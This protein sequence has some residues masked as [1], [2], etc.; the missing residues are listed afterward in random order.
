MARNKFFI[1]RWLGTILVLAMV[2]FAAQA[3]AAFKYIHE[4]M[5][6]QDF[7]GVDLV[8]GEKL[9][10]RKIRQG[11]LPIIIF[12]A[13]WSPRSQEQLEDVKEML[14]KY[15]EES[16][17]VIAVNVDGQK[18]T[19]TGRQKVIDYVAELNPPFSVMIDEGLDIFY[20]FG[21]IAVPSTAISDS[22]GILRFG[23]GGYA[24]STRDLLI[25]SIEAFLGIIQPDKAPKPKGYTPKK[26]SS[27][28]YYLASNLNKRG[29]FENALK[30]VEMARAADSNF[31]GP[32]TLQGEILMKLNRNDEAQEVFQVASVLDTGAVTIWAGWGRALLKS[33]KFEE[34]AEKLARA[35]KIDEAYTPAF[36]DYGLCLARMGKFEGA[37]D[38]LIIAVGLN[39]GDPLGHYYLGMAYRQAGRHEEAI[40]SLLTALTLIYPGD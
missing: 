15:N 32:L 12:W 1:R 24:L 31:A 17:K 13:T 10:F 29:M 27:R 21:V 38:S 37:I 34:A 40:K 36:L 16:I 28:Y 8:T 3:T 39:P 18:L 6:I 23:P 19:P 4:G 14:E 30:N 22:T 7:S 35:M 11:S 25:D 33:E 2:L 5:E 20:K 26:K 9:S